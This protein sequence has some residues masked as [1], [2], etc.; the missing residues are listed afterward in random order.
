MLLTI[1]LIL[2]KGERSV[3]INWDLLMLPH[4]VFVIFYIWVQW[5]NTQNRYQSVPVA[6]ML[7]FIVVR[8]V[9]EGM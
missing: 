3:I 5:L 6:H 1:G 2:I 8:S 4:A 9:A 7:G